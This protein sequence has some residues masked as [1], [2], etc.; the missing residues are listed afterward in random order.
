MSTISAG[1]STIAPRALFFILDSEAGGSEV[2][3]RRAHD[4]D[5]V[6]RTARRG[7]RLTCF[8]Q[9]RTSE[10]SATVRSTGPKRRQATIPGE[11][12][13]DRGAERR[14]VKRGTPGVAGEHIA[15]GGSDAA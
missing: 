8:L 15:I 5:A 9:G 3:K 10:H 6:H 4:G 12:A 11:S 7:R 1:L 14:V 2:A 13:N